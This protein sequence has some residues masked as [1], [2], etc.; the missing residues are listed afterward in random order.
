MNIWHPFWLPKMVL[1]GVEEKEREKLRARW[2]TRPFMYGED[3]PL[4]ARESV[5]GNDG[6]VTVQSAMWG[7]FLGILEGC[8]RKS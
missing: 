5:W 8:D 6:L 7:E 1:D 2:E 4:W 3:T